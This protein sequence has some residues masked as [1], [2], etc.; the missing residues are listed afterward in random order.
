MPT[1]TNE[2]L[3]SAACIPF[4]RTLM[5]FSVSLMKRIV[6]EENVVDNLTK[7][8]RK[9]IPH[10][11]SKL[12]LR[13][14]EMEENENVEPLS[15]SKLARELGYKS[16]GSFSR[17]IKSLEEIGLI[18]CRW[19]KITLTQKGLLVWKLL[20][21]PYYEEILKV[22]ENFVKTKGKMPSVDDII[23]ELKEDRNNTELMK[24]IE[25]MLKSKKVKRILSEATLKFMS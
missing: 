12:Y 18:K 7:I 16:T 10:I 6:Y 1:V 23:I 11:L 21:T 25:T 13:H 22:V 14:L 2:L 4:D 20:A 3:D 17:Y 24:M 5:N 15:M 19:N 9:G 8:F